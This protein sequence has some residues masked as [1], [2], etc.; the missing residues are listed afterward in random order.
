M[1]Y[2]GYTL[3][4]I[5]NHPAND[6]IQRYVSWAGLE[7]NSDA[8]YGFSIKLKYRLWAFIGEMELPIA[9]D[10]KYVDLLANNSTCVNS[11]GQ[12]VEC[13]TDG[14]VGEFDFYMALINESIII[15][16]FIVAKIEWADQEGKFNTF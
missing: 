10:A 1:Q 9:P 11:Q 3:Y 7:I 13:D 6:N 12:I 15:Q 14:A 16:S 2:Q 4:P 8:N 5:S